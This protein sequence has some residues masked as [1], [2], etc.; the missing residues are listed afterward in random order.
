MVGGM[1]RPEVVAAPRCGT[2]TTWLLPLHTVPSSDRTVA[3]TIFTTG[4]CNVAGG[5]SNQLSK[6]EQAKQRMKRLK[7]TIW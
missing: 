5:G 6:K 1:D 7:S 3:K 4:S 2:M